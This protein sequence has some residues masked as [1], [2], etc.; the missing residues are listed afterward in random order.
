[1]E[2]DRTSEVLALHAQFGN[3]VYQTNND[4]IIAAVNTANLA[5]GKSEVGALATWSDAELRNPLPKSI[6]S[7]S[8]TSTQTRIEEPN[9]V[10]NRVVLRQAGRSARTMAR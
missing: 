10:G 3:T 8:S 9:V 1:M 2:A 7:K 6:F 5:A 4:K